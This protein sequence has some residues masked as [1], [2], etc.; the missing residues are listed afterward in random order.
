MEDQGGGEA[1][2]V[3]DHHPKK[4]LP[5]VTGWVCEKIPQNVAQPILDKNWYFYRGKCSTKIGFPL[6]F[7]NQPKVNKNGLKINQ[8]G[9]P[10]PTRQMWL[11]SESGPGLLSAW[12]VGSNPVKEIGR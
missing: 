12:L 7:K 5:R 9:H 2:G 1:Q 11:S 6:Y 4:I 10:D 3:A 8:S